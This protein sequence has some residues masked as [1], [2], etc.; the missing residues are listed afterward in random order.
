MADM[1]VDN[2]PEAPEAILPEPASKASPRAIEIVTRA[3]LGRVQTWAQT[4]P[5][6]I[7]PVCRVQNS[8][9]PLSPTIFCGQSDK[10]LWSYKNPLL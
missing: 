9:G 7:L 6:G 2:D 10:Y 8:I 3:P 4:S 1:S 5:Q